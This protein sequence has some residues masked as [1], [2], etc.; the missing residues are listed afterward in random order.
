[1]EGEKTTTRGAA[2]GDARGIG[3]AGGDEVI[4]DLAQALVG[5]GHEV[6]A[7][8]ATLPPAGEF[9]RFVGAA[10]GAVAGQINGDAEVAVRGECVA[11][12]AVIGVAEGAVD[13]AGENEE[14][15]RGHGL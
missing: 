2:G 7:A 10:L 5:L 14:R 3:V 1:M 8:L 6:V 11:G 12:L 13:G 4:E 15:G 9:R